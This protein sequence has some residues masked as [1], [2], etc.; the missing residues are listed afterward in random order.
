MEQ[1]T[2][3]DG[4][5]RNG[6]RRWPLLVAVAI[7]AL[8]T[9]LYL[10]LSLLYFLE[11]TDLDLATI[12]VLVSVTTAL[13]LPVPIVV[14]RL[15]DRFGPRLVVAGGQALQGFGFLRGPG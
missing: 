15:V 6:R 2:A 4:T 10:P 13:T 1:A 9:G 12:G 3:D 7:D 14:G 11:V 8:G 5:P